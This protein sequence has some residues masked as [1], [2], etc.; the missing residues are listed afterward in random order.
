VTLIEHTDSR[1]TPS[2]ATATWLATIIGH[3]DSRHAERGNGA[4]YRRS[5][6]RRSRHG[7]TGLALAAAVVFNGA[8]GT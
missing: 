2:A 5:T 7:S 4:A 1:A 8:Y 3:T 6:G